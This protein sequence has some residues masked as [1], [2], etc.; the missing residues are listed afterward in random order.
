MGFAAPHGVPSGLVS[1]LP[2]RGLGVFPRQPDVWDSLA[3]FLV[4]LGG[5]VAHAAV[6]LACLWEEL[7]SGSFYVAMCNQ[8]SQVIVI[9]L[10]I[11]S[12]VFSQ[13][14]NL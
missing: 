6:D 7:S 11:L 4:F 13:G 2:H 14:Q 12:I 1:R 10:F 5:R 9:H 8:P 3:Y